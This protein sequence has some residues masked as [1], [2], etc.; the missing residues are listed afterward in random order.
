MAK[1]K[2]KGIIFAIF[3]AVISGVSIFVNKFAVTSIHEPLVFTAV[4]NTGVALIVLSLLLS[5]GEIKKIKSLTKK[6][7]IYLAVIGV[8]GGSIPFYLFFTG[9]SMIPAINAALIQKTLVLW[10]AILAIPF[11]KEKLSKTGI[12]SILLLF[13]ANLL[14]GGFSGFQYSTGEM[15][16]LAATVFWAIE[17]ILAKKVLPNIHPDLLVEAR[18]GI[19]AVVLLAFSA[20]LKPQALLGIATLSLDNWLWLLFTMGLLTGYV[21][22]WYRGLKYSPATVVTAVLVG[23]TLVT[24]ILSAVFVTHMLNSVLL[25]QSALIILGIGVLYK[26]EATSNKKLATI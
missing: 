11:L 9:L 25:V 16:V 22:T 1:T 18:M 3:T 19:G 4:K 24:N 21:A 17:T 7:L 5:S 26:F 15:Y 8:I 12:F 14:V 23:S 13:A 20:V 10:V 2:N 6:E